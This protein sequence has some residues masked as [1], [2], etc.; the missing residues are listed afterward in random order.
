MV[1]KPNRKAHD[2]QPMVVSAFSVPQNYNKV[3]TVGDRN[4]IAPSL[5][6]RTSRLRE[7]SGERSGAV[8]MKSPR[9]TEDRDCL[10]A[11]AHLGHLEH[12]TVNELG[13][14]WDD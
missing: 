9:Q 14:L 4:E 1:N 2:T 5:L 6:P 7:I 13:G 11:G 12:W 8:H 10:A 3:P